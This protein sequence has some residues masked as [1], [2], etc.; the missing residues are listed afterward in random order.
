MPIGSTDFS[1][2]ARA[3]PT[4]LGSAAGSELGGVASNREHIPHEFPPAEGKPKNAL[5]Q[6][7]DSAAA[8]A[9]IAFHDRRR[10]AVTGVTA[11]GGFRV[12]HSVT[13]ARTGL[14]CLPNCV[15][16]WRVPA[17]LAP[18]AAVDEAQADLDSGYVLPNA[19]RAASNSFREAR[20]R[21]DN[22]DFVTVESL[23]ML[24]VLNPM[25]DI[26]ILGTGP[27]MVAPS[28]EVM[29]FLRSLNVPFEFMSTF[30]AASTFN[31]LNEEDRNVA[32]ALVPVEFK[33]DLDT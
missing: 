16:P 14:F 23:A 29:Q 21:A 10:V 20:T 27:H 24:R 18:S 26:F 32:A 33:G 2:T 25:A 19:L 30:H 8:L 6:V 15:I 4:T 12:D 17:V 3:P 7:E 13:F 11:S 5:V 1:R 31:I 28:K 22:I 9:P